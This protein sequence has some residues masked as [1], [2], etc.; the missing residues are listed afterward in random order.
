M[1]FAS[2]N[3]SGAAPE[4][5]A[6]L[7]RANDGFATAY[8]G[9]ALTAAV[10]ARFSAVF[11][12]PV[13]VHFVATGTAA[14]ALSM[15]A[16]ARPGGLI[17]CSAEAHLRNDEY[18]ASE[19]FTSGMKP[20]G[21]PTRLDK[22]S[23]DGLVETLARFPEGNRTGRPT[24]L[25][26]TE[27]TEGG[28]LY[29]IA[30]VT[31]LA[32]I[33]K[34]SGLHVH[35]D[36]ARFANAAASLGVTPAELTWKAGIDL[37]S[38]GGTKNG[39]WAADAI[40][41]FTP[42]KFPDLPVIKSRAGHTFSKSRFVAAQ[43]D[44]YLSDDNWLRYAGHAN[45]MAKRLA[46]DLTSSGKGRLGWTPQANEVFVVL[47]RASIDRLRAASAMFHPWPSGEVPVGADEQLVRLVASW[48]TSERDVDQFVA[49]A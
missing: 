27:A 43:F 34:Q 44:A 29:S 19:F 8:G 14:N 21:L 15:A 35:M 7:T 49:L 6:A 22:V 48:A 30:E 13:E 2:D 41:V 3:W 5:M 24:V 28:T 37:M 4:V 25:S 18:G 31:E 16:C 26:L 36:G 46:D 1:N 11:E 42:G 32:A 33:A 10:T 12:R 47:K 38:F 39:C 23:R 40:V 9:D 45:R 17:L 20:V